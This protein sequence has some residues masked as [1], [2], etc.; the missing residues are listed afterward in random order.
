MATADAVTLSAGASSY[1]WVDGW[2]RMPDTDSARLG[3]APSRG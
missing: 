3:W 2:A 1:E